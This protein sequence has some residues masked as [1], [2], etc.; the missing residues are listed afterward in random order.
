MRAA[1]RSGGGVH[2]SPVLSTAAAP[3]TKE[4]LGRSTWTFL[5]TLAAQF[6]DKP[7]KSQRKDVERLVLVLT[8]AL[9]SYAFC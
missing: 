4:S 2:A 3:T 8:N 1:V 5:H 7:S 6:P 9:L